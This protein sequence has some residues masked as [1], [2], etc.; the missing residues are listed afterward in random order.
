MNMPIVKRAEIAFWDVAIQAMSQNEPIR[1]AIRI[2]HKAAQP[3]RLR[4]VA[5][6]L[7]ITACSGLLSGMIL[8][9]VTTYLR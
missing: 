9:L 5:G 7:A 1:R 8:G 4:R 2:I 3:S 6:L